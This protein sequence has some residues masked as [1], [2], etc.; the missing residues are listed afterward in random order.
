M[1]DAKE[2]QSKELEQE[3][4]ECRSSASVVPIFYGL[5]RETPEAVK[6]GNAVLGGCCVSKEK[7]YCKKCEL[8]FSGSEEESPDVED[9]QSHTDQKEELP[10]EFKNCKVYMHCVIELR[11]APREQRWFVIYKTNDGRRCIAEL[12]RR[13]EAVRL[14][15]KWVREPPI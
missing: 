13:V 3:C 4:P 9:A 1:E 15:E 6:S 12:S 5:F 7:F 8:S 11:K 10:G 14:S 2:P